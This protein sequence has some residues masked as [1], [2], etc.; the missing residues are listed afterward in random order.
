MLVLIQAAAE[1]LLVVFQNAMQVLLRT[2]ERA[3]AFVSTPRGLMVAL[4]AVVLLVLTV[5]RRRRL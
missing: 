3:Y 5:G 1:Y 4:A 2:G